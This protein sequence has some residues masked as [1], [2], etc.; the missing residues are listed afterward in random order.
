MAFPPLGTYLRAEGRPVAE[1]WATVA[2]AIV[3]FEPV[4]MLVPP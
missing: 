2:N 3:D 1:A 4:T